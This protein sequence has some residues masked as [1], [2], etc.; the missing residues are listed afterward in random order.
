MECVK[1]LKKQQTLFTKQSTLQ[2]SATEASFMVAY[3]LAKR[4]KPFSDG[5][6]IKQCMVECASELC[7]DVRSKFENI[8]LSRRTIV[9]RIDSISD[10]FT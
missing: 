6:F 10:E 3:N 5:E 2:N 7:P 4:N 8:S 9:R 1:K